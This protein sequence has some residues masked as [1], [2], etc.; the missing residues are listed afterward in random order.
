MPSRW[1]RGIYCSIGCR[2]DSS[3]SMASRT[4][5]TSADQREDRFSSTASGTSHDSAFAG[6]KLTHRKRFYDCP[7]NNPLLQ[8]LDLK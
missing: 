7:W 6:Y 2:H 3:T 4:V 1:P 5:T 8:G